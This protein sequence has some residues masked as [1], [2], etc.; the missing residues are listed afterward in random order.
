LNLRPQSLASRSAG[1][2]V[3]KFLERAENAV[4]P[5]GTFTQHERESECHLPKEEKMV[6]LAHVN[7]MATADED[8]TGGV[9]E[10]LKHPD[11][12]PVRV[13]EELLHGLLV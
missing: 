13:S 7:D 10:L 6:N 4:I 3:K 12:S 5:V 1:S 2:D 9:A 8:R 11:P